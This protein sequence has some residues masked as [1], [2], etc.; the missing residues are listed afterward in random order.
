[1]SGSGVELTNLQLR[2]KCREFI[3]QLLPSSA[4]EVKKKEVILHQKAL[5]LAQETKREY[6]EVYVDLF[7]ELHALHTAKDPMSY[8]IQDQIGW[9]SPL[10]N[11]HVEKERIDIVNLTKPMEVEDGIYTCPKCKGNKTFFY[12]RQMRSADEPMTTIITCANTDCQ[13]RWKIN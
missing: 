10:F 13:Y 1:M 12:S 11:D 6:R 3:A 4:A 9:T 8:F 2:E 5:K 7:M